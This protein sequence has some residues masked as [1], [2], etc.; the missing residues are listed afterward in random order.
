MSLNNFEQASWIILLFFVRLIQF[1]FSLFFFK[2][3]VFQ[4]KFE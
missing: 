1:K 2:K 3:Q 4:I